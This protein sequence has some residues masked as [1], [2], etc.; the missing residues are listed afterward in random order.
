MCRYFDVAPG[1]GEHFHQTLSIDFAICIEGRIELKLDIGETRIMEKGDIVLQRVTMHSWQNASETEWCHLVAV[2]L[3][4]KEFKFADQKI[5][6]HPGFMASIEKGGGCEPYSVLFKGT[7]LR[8]EIREKI[9]WLRLLINL[10]CVSLRTHKCLSFIFS[11]IFEVDLGGLHHSLFIFAVHLQYFRFPKWQIPLVT[12][13][14]RSRAH[15][16][17]YLKY[18]C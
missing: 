5:E 7:L 8:F 11:R 10:S 3:P 14:S 4:A 1:N 16:L 18:V 15:D 17:R 6:K 13:G 12:N 2:M 9:S